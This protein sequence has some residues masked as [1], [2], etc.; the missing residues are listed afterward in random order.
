MGVGGAVV[1][2]VM[3]CSSSFCCRWPGIQVREA[4]ARR[5]LDRD[6]L[7]LP[8]GRG[9]RQLARGAVVREEEHAHG[10]YGDGGDVEAAAPGVFLGHALISEPLINVAHDHDG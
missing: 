9:V 7:A 3:R 8:R 10:D 5:L 1:R 2:T 4:A 6:L